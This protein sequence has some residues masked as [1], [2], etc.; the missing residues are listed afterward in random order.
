MINQRATDNPV[1]NI[2]KQA[3][4]IWPE[5]PHWDLHNC[6][7]R[8][9]KSFDL[10]KVP[11]RARF[12]VTADQS[13]HLYLNG[14]FVCRGP[15]R[16][17]QSHWPYDE[18]DVSP[19]LR[20]GKNV[21][22][23][24]AHNPGF[25]NFQ[26]LS[27][28]FAGVLAGGEWGDVKIVTNGTWLMR[29]E[30][31]ISK[32]TVPTSVQLFCQEHRDARLEP[33]DWTSL[34][35]DESL[36]QTAPLPGFSTSDGQDWNSMPW[37]TLEAR[38]IP[39]LAEK[40]VAPKKLLGISSGKCAKDYRTTRDVTLVRHAEGLR[41]SPVSK[42]EGFAP[43]HVPATGARR[44][45][46]YL[47]DFGMTVVGNISLEVEGG[48]GGEIIDTLHV[49]AINETNLEA[50]LVIPS[51]CRTA[52]GNRLICREGRTR[53]TFYHA[54][55]F[56]YLVLT[57]R[58]S[59]QPLE[60]GLKLNW[61]GY[62]LERKGAFL[63]SD[64]SLNGIWETC[65]WTQQC[66]ALDAYVDTPW[67]EQAQWWGDARVQAQNTFFLSNDARLL[68]RGI[69]SIGGQTTP[70]GLTYGHAPTM[71]HSC[72][73]PD[74]TLIWILTIWDYY[75][76]TG[77]L[78]A[79]HAH[80]EGIARAL[81][82]FANQ[83]DPKTGLA[84]YDPR[85]WMFLDWCEIFRDG[86]STLPNLWLLLA[87][88][89]TAR[90]HRLS[91]NPEKAKPLEKWGAKLKKSLTA[92]INKEG[93]LCDG[94]T[95]KKKI[96]PTTAIHNQTLALLTNLAPRHERAMLDRI[97]LPF[98]REEIK[99]AVTPSVYWITYVFSVLSER[100][101]K[102]EVLDYIKKYWTP[103]AAH[104]TTWESF[105]PN[106]GDACGSRSHAWSAHPLYHLMQTVGGINQTA[107]AWKEIRFEPFFYDEKG[108]ATVPTPQGKIHSEWK[109]TGSGVA[110]KLVLPP[111][112]RARVKLPGVKPQWFT[113]THTWNIACRNC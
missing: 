52:F 20:K 75:W 72:I 82:Y 13:Y 51:H 4:W 34:D 5:S 61:I 30:T 36:W 98:I 24:R 39:L 45:C 76:Q 57:V 41:H 73:L 68:R 27:Q 70:N 102:R 3:R 80:E 104:G 35:F 9:R 100:G 101:Y 87:L 48:K 113:G 67:R 17:Y 49:E 69:A 28:G 37:F 95:W 78:E 54:F 50:H 106:A 2:L 77:S 16:G 23:I 97:L 12:Y 83:T 88:E 53:H 19:Y 112:V 55:G 1:P 32:D 66:C 44:F 58:D 60:I 84:K 71:A 103:M 22:A 109:R 111:G 18:V 107:P 6:Y 79:F 40:A 26:Y 59:M 42:A 92:L 96:V 21:I 81:D 65:A 62:P 11:G 56:R 86:Y 99:P 43:L 105:N 7:A 63:S 64:A 46:S 38:G 47:I 25:S 90:L 10:K 8:F 15:A 110:V 91:G 94:L 93:L 85:Y 108:S 29:R 14:K 33:D 89:K 31:G 74:F